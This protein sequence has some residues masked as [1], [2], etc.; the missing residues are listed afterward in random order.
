MNQ[1][2]EK[3]EILDVP[4]VESAP[5]DLKK[6]WLEHLAKA[7]CPSSGLAQLTVPPREPILGDWF[8]QGDLGFIFGARGLGKT[9]LAMLIARR[10]AE[11]GTVGDWKV[12]HLVRFTAPVIALHPPAIMIR[13]D[14]CRH[15]VM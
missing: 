2:L 6:E 5:V 10:C 12:H 7:T 13:R 15:P 4:E 1:L 14:D 11:G 8:K 3:P 9:W